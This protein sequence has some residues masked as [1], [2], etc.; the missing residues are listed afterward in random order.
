LRSFRS[1]L[2]DEKSGEARSDVA[3]TTGHF[4][5]VEPWYRSRH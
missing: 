2:L 5:V 3:E 1:D 4:P